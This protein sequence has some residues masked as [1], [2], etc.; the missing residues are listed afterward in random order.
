LPKFNLLASISVIIFLFI[1]GCESDEPTISSNCQS[2]ECAGNED[3][4]SELNDSSDTGG[5]FIIEYP[6]E[7]TQAEETVIEE[8]PPVSNLGLR[9]VLREH[10]DNAEIDECDMAPTIDWMRGLES[11]SDMGLTA[12]HRSYEVVGADD[13]S[14]VAPDS[15][16]PEYIGGFE[17][18]KT[19]TDANGDP[20]ITDPQTINYAIR[21]W[22]NI[23]FAPGFYTIRYNPEEPSEYASVFIADDTSPLYQAQEGVINESIYGLLCTGMTEDDIHTFPEFVNETTQEIEIF[24]YYDGDDKG[25]MNIQYRHATAEDDLSDATWV[26]LNKGDENSPIQLT[27]Q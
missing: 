14:I 4:G 22:G 12:S 25:G 26:P 13:F 17:N 11:N 1:S 15:L 16:S 21:W 8:V 18:I 10:N 24:W 27:W 19:E 2:A 23:T 6:A 5:G 9:A 7:N 3:A 20:A